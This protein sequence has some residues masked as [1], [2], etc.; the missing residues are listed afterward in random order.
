MRGLKISSLE[1]S[2]RGFN[3]AW[4]EALGAQGV[5]L[6]NLELVCDG[7][8][9]GAE[10]GVFRTLRSVSLKDRYPCV[11]IGIGPLCDLPLLARLKLSNVRSL[12]DP[13][14][15]CRATRLENLSLE[16]CTEVGP[17]CIPP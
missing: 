17:L 16:G 6:T 13:E 7:L 9:V 11:C 12:L 1:W 2:D 15:L 5:P 3:D 14:T 8:T 4:L 10:F